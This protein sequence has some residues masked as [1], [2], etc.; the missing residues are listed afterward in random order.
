MKSSFRLPFLL[1]LGL[2]LHSG[3]AFAQVKFDLHIIPVTGEIPKD[4][5]KYSQFKTLNERYQALQEFQSVMY[6]RGYL[7]FSIDSILESGTKQFAYISTGSSF[8]WAALG[9][10]NLDGDVLGSIKFKDKLFYNRDINPRQVST[11]FESILTHCENNGYPFAQVKF[12]SIVYSAEGI[13]AVLNLDKNR[14]VTIDSVL[15]KGSNKTIPSYF[16]Q[17]LGLKP[18]MLYDESAIRLSETR[19]K[20]LPFA[21]AFR[22]TE[23]IFTEKSTKI[24]LY[25]NHKKASRFDGII[26]FQPNEETG[27]ISFTGDV[28]LNVKNG[29]K[30]GETIVLNWRRLQTATQ[31]LLVEFR[32]PYLFK[33]PFGADL[34]FSLYRRDTSFVQIKGNFGVVYQLAGGDYIKIFAQPQQSNVLSKVFTPSNGLASV[35]LTM[36][37]LEFQKSR[38]NYRFNPVQGYGVLINGA[39]GNKKIRKNPEFPESFYEDVELTSVQWTASI[40]ANFFVP[41]SKRNTIMIAGKGA[42]LQNE[43]MFINELYRIGG[44]STIRGFDEESIF[45][46]SYGILTLEY[47]FL[48]EQNSNLFAFAEGAWYETNTTQS[49]VTDT[50]IG[51]GAGMSFE[52]KAGIFS[53]TYALG[54]QFDN[55][56]QLR[57]GKIHFGFSNFF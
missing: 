16:H 35:D 54:K 11:L 4:I 20:E 41:I 46:S 13:T 40:N 15:V 56:I 52:T 5:S 57:N 27:K 47:R 1:I 7:A 55:P 48:L 37:G 3:H 39:F 10:G 43:S 28:K 26:G 25:L 17:Y 12:D 8:K 14:L 50:P 49:F 38:Y 51:F 18:G 2:I 21:T 42:M 34:S 9:K 33:T 53:L 19:I 24:Q 30:Q 23:V 6:K 31:D 32:Y 36:F 22:P 29:F 44:M 45:A